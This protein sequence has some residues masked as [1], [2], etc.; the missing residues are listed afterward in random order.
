M[1]K[2]ATSFW[3]VLFVVCALWSSSALAQTPPAATGAGVGTFNAAT[4]Y[5]GVLLSGLDFGLGVEI[6]GDT[7][8]TGE[9]HATLQGTSGQAIGVD[10]HASSGSILG[11]GSATISGTCTVDK[12]DGSGPSTGVAFTVTAVPDNTG[13]G[14]LTLTLG[15]TSLASA[16]IQDGSL[17]VH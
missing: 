9:F 10:G 11:D 15:S 13:R 14:T 7:S 16:S 3:S 1:K 4:T 12:G 6:P 8:A 5:S 2:P 17:T